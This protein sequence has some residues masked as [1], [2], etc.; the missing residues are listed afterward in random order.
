MSAF[1]A[2]SFTYVG[3]RAFAPGLSKTIRA[4]AACW[5]T[6]NLY[7]KARR[8]ADTTARQATIAMTERRRFISG[9][10]HS[11]KGFSMYLV[12]R[13]AKTSDSAIM[14]VPESQPA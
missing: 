14:A 2:T 5:S 4:S 9:H 10:F 13:K 6:S 3:R 12:V 1:G 11:R 8:G 7:W